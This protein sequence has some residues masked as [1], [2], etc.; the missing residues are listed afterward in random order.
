MPI[1]VQSPKERRS[2]VV[3]FWLKTDVLR[4]EILDQS[5]SVKS[6]LC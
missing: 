4:A 5:L 3:R 6:S 2:L 1:L